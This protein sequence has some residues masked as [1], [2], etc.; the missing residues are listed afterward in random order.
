MNSY[1]FAGLNK[2]NQNL[3]LKGIPQ[4]LDEHLDVIDFVCEA[5]ELNRKDVVSSSRKRPFSEAR[6]I[7]IGI[8]KE[9]QSCLSLV[10]IGKIFGGRNHATIINANKTYEDL[11]GTDRDF[12]NKVNRV[13][14]YM[15]KNNF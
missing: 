9:A 12:T 8:M 3:I 1:V 4:N 2:R 11:Y 5:L 6:F 10:K 15:F 13:K 14:E 7:A